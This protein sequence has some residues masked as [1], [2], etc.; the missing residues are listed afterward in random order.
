MVH[1]NEYVAGWLDSSIGDFLAELP[2]SSGSAAYALITC[3]DSSFD[4]ASLLKKNSSLRAAMN[5]VN[6]LKKGVIVPLKLL[7]RA[8]LRDQLLVGFDEIWFF[9]TD[10]IEPKPES[11]SI[12]GPNRIDQRTLDKLGSWMGANGCSLAL[13]DGGGLNIIVKAHGLVKYVIAHSLSQ[14]EPTFQMSELWVQDEEKKLPKTG[15]RARTR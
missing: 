6:M 12:V 7:Q 3:L 11:A 14:P 4:P 5:G 9:P 2:R 10:R 1:Y 13:G 8:S 15:R